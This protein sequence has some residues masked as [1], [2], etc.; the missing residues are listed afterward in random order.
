VFWFWICVVVFV[1]VVLR[2]RFY[3]LVAFAMLVRFLVWV[4]LCLWCY[5]VLYIT[6][7]CFC[8]VYFVVFGALFST[9]CLRLLAGIL[10]ICLFW[11]FA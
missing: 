2:F 1:F 6:R 11:L 10:F 4:Y 5:V 3:S 8:F 7:L 9:V